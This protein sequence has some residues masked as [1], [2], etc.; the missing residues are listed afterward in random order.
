M[1]DPVSKKTEV[2]SNLRPHLMLTFPPHTHT[3]TCTPH[4]CAG[5]QKATSE[6]YTYI[7]HTYVR[8]TY[9]HHHTSYIY[10]PIRPIGLH[11]AGVSAEVVSVQLEG[12]WLDSGEAAGVETTESNREKGGVA[13]D[14]VQAPAQDAGFL[15]LAHLW[16]SQAHPGLRQEHR[17][18]GR[19][20]NPAG[21]SRT[22]VSTSIP[23]LNSRPS[24]GPAPW[25]RHRE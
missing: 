2:S 23:H 5:T 8:H 3:H 1:R 21:H 6:L 11:M 20:R 19:G 25:T 12:T 24:L 18:G 13:V 10:T 15:S 22:E 4:R 9:I 14:P 16:P 7:I 17:T